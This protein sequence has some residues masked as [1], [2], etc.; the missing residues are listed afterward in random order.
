MP[1]LSSSS[2][3]R[4][5]L[6]D[7]RPLSW[8][9]SRWWRTRRYADAGPLFELV[10]PPPLRLRLRYGMRPGRLCRGMVGRPRGRRRAPTLRP[11]L[12]AAV[13][14]LSYRFT[15]ALLDRVPSE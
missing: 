15:V 12:L 7:R 5:P 9:S 1:P 2:L 13:S 3:P 11:P 10:R 4:M 6:G 8:R 14:E